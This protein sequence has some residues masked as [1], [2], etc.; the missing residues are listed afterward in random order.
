MPSRCLHLQGRDANRKLQRSIKAA[1][2]RERL[3]ALLAVAE[4]AVQEWQVNP[5]TGS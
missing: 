1:K 3:P 2:M 5:L 4:Q